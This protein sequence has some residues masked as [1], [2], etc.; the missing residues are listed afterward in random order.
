MRLVEAIEYSLEVALRYAD[1]EILHSYRGSAVVDM[2]GDDNALGVRRILYSVSDEVGEH[3]SD[4]VRIEYE[5]ARPGASQL[6]GDM[7]ADN[8]LR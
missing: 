4:P 3:L 2:A 7:L 6:T 5:C 1:P 8:R